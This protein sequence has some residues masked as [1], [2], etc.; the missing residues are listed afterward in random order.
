VKQAIL[1]KNSNRG[2]EAVSENHAVSEEILNHT[3]NELFLSLIF[4]SRARKAL[5]ESFI[6]AVFLGHAVS[7][8]F[9]Q[10]SF[11]SRRFGDL[12]IAVKDR[13]RY[14]RRRDRSG[15]LRWQ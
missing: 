5:S 12:I 13:D 6:S 4:I 15:W 3:I 2:G 9:S 7:S 8:R 11:E 1:G 10:S 14:A